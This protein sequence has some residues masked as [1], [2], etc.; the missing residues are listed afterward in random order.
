MKEE[1]IKNIIDRLK[2]GASVC[3]SVSQ[4]RSFFQGARR[5]IN[6]LYGY[7]ILNENEYKELYEKIDGEVM[8]QLEAETKEIRS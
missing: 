5:L 6:T 4:R 3:S 8:K 7:E 1:Q 2:N